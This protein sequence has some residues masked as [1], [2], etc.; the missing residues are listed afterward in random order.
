MCGRACGLLGDHP[1]LCTWMFGCNSNSA[2]HWSRNRYHSHADEAAD[3]YAGLM[4]A[5]VVSRR[6]ASRPD[7]TPADVDREFVLF[8]R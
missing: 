3:T 2:R 7:G 1:R 5:I 8:F 4:G 6:G